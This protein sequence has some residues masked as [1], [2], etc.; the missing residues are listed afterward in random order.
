MPVQLCSHLIELQE[1]ARRPL[2][3]VVLVARRTGVEVVDGHV[4]DLLLAER[5][6]VGAAS[7][8]VLRAVSFAA[9]AALL[10]IF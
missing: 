5:A 7:D 4:A 2:L 9:P 8:P 6:C 3:V 1:H 10:A